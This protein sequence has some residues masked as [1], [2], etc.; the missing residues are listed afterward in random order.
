MW[1]LAIWDTKEQSLFLS[2][3]RFGK[4]P[5]FYSQLGSDF[6]F[7]SEMKAI[8]SL[9]PSVKI[10]QKLV[11]DI[12][13]IFYYES[14]EECLIEGIKRF[15]AGHYGWY[16]NGELSLARYWHTL[17]QLVVVPDKYEDQVEQFRALFLDAVKLRMRADVRIG[18]AL[19]GGLDSSA[20]FGAIAKLSRTGAGDRA[21]TDWQHAFSATFPGTPLDELVWAEK[22]A[23]YCDAPITPVTIDP[24][25]H[26]ATFFEDIYRFEELYITPHIPFM[27][28]YGAMKQAGVTVTLDGHGADELF[29]GYSFDYLHI[30]HDEMWNYRNSQ[31]VIDTYYESQLTDGTQFASLPPKSLFWLKQFGKNAAKK[32][33]RQT[34]VHPDVTHPRF[35]SFDYFTQKLYISFHQTVLPTLLRNYDRYSM[36]RGVEIRMPFMD[37]RIVS[38]AFSLPWQSK[39][40]NGYTKAIVRDAVADFIPNEVAY[41]KT[42]I[43]FNAPMV[44]WFKGPMQTFFT[45]TLASKDFQ[46]CNLI[47]T[48]AVTKEVQHI[49]ANPKATF[50]DAER[51]WKKISPFFW[52]RGFVKK[53]KS[54]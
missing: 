25:D 20:V 40:R 15:P 9:L 33:L 31:A 37:H 18:T 50:H 7:A 11:D 6:T 12:P 42:K 34:N 26:L 19:S 16:K 43:G 2:R 44:D 36:A 45:E 54:D 22:V 13:H 29:G 47:D 39:V 49:I 52:E 17:D 10:N 35:Q 5:L 32:L 53:L 21:S 27:A 38:Y 3:D 14:T 51:V 23:T 41:R 8:A 30:L 46:Q 48:K 4:K 28:T 1:T 24:R